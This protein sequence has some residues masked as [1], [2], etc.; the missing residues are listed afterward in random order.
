MFC[1]TKVVPYVVVVL[2]STLDNEKFHSSN[3]L[4]LERIVVLYL[5][6]EI[7]KQRILFEILIL[8]LRHN[9]N[10]HPAVIVVLKRFVFLYHPNS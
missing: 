5:N 1:T 7:Q 10:L 2:A 6:I 8:K 3:I 4:I 9:D